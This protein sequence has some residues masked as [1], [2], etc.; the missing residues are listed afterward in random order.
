MT[1]EGGGALV[2]LSIALLYALAV[3]SLIRQARRS[4]EGEKPR[5]QQV[6]IPLPHPEEQVPR[7]R[8]S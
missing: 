1:A 4:D 7:R 6:E 8:A 2:Y 3:R 5:E